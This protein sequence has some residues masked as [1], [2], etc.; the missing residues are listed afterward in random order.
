MRSALRNFDQELR[1]PG[2]LDPERLRILR[3]ALEH[4]DDD[5]GEWARKVAEWS[6]N[7]KHHAWG[8]DGRGTLGE[9]VEDE[10]LLLWANAVYEE[11]QPLDIR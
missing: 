10:D 5:T 2:A 7:P 4:W 6:V 1:L 9:M 8:V 11:I 3:N